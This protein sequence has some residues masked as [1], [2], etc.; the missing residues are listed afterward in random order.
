MNRGKFP[1]LK[2]LIKEENT[3]GRL[4]SLRNP[5]DLNLGGPKVPKKQFAPNL[6]VVRNKDKIKE[7]TKKIEH[8][9]NVRNDKYSKRNNSDQRFIQSSG[10]FS[11]GIGLDAKRGYRTRHS[12]TKENDVTPSMTVPT[13]KKNSWEVDRKNE[14]NIFDQIMATEEDIEDE[15]LP[16][17]ILSWTEQDFK[18]VAN[19]IHI[20]SEV[21]DIKSEPEEELIS[22]LTI[23]KIKLE[24]SDFPLEYQDENAC[25]DENPIITLWRLP[26][27]FAGKTVSDDQDC[28]KLFDYTLHEMPEGQIGK[29]ILRKSGL[30][31]IRVGKMKYSLEPGDLGSCREEIVSLD[32][33]ENQESLA[34]VLGQ[35][36]NRFLLNPDWD[37]LFNANKL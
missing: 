22:K 27:S 20:K 32:I 34:A 6:N 35:I 31:E 5:R 29:L 36:Q 12:N 1:D 28:K 21:K 24:N 17:Q 13:I 23:N 25:S 19:P 10:V 8:K 11:D 14:E 33:K 37:S 26:D 3:P 15:K 16:F 7:V 2:K 4:Q 18:V 30:L 9:R